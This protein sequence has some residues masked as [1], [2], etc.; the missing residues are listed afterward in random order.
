MT[1]C[2]NLPRSVQCGFQGFGGDCILPWRRGAASI[3][4]HRRKKP[5]GRTFG[6]WLIH[7]EK[8]HKRNMGTL[9][10]SNMFRVAVE[11]GQFEDDLHALLCEI[12]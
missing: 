4:L 5:G 10:E 2:Q 3:K 7:L 12:C 1:T 11:N 6:R 8:P 9:W